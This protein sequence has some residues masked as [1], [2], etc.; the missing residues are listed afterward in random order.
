MVCQ[1]ALSTGVR[2]L[3]HRRVGQWPHLNSVGGAPQ[4]LRLRAVTVQKQAIPVVEFWFK[5]IISG[6]VQGEEIH[7]SGAFM[8]RNDLIFTLKMTALGAAALV[9]YVAVNLLRDGDLSWLRYL[10]L[11]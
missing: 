4:L 5:T 7:V 11:R 6:Y 9:I 1:A 8:D 3:T 10:M 2:E